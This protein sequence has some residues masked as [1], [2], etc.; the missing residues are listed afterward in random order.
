MA[1]DVQMAQTE[2][3]SRFSELENVKPLLTR[4]VVKFSRAVSRFSSVMP[5]DFKV[6]NI[7]ST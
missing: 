2:T 4:P 6:S 1:G 5:I 7:S 3:V